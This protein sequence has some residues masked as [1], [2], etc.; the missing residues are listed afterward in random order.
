VTDIDPRMITD[1]E[2]PFLERIHDLGD[3]NELRRR[4]MDEDGQS[5]ATATGLAGYMLALKVGDRD[6]VPA[7][8]RRTEYRAILRRLLDNE[9]PKTGRGRRR[10]LSAVD[11]E[12]GY[13]D[14]GTLGLVSVLAMLAVALRVDA[15]ALAAVLLDVTRNP[16]EL[17]DEAA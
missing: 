5:R 12:G 15:G 16:A 1:A 6:A 11:G 9:R 7:A 4:A 8:P 3:L 14:A 13:V 10:H 2:A 17:L